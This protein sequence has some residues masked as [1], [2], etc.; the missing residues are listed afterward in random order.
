MSDPLSPTPEERRRRAEDQE[1][2]N[3]EASIDAEIEAD[4][5]WEDDQCNIQWDDE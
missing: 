3:W 2:W 4:R 5:Q 1:R